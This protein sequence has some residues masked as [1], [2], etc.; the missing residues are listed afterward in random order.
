MS[1]K[2]SLR[3]G[4]TSLPAELILAVGAE[5]IAPAPGIRG[6]SVLDHP[7][8]FR[9]VPT[10]CGASRR[11]LTAACP[12][13]GPGCELAPPGC[14]RRLEDSRGRGQVGCVGVRTSGSP[15]K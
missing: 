7:S 15:S 9:E 12:V 4:L 6:S 11:A 2:W 10:M 8:M 3:D 5:R 13:G 14:H 1:K